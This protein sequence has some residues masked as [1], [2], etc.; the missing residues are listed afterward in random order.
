M[1]AEKDVS[2]SPKRFQ[3]WSFT[4]AVRCHAGRPATTREQALIMKRWLLSRRS[5]GF[6][7][8]LALCV[9]GITLGWRAAGLS[10]WSAFLMGLATVAGM[11]VASID[12]WLRPERFTVRRLWFPALLMVLATYLGILI[13]Q[14]LGPGPWYLALPQLLWQATPLQS[15]L[16][17]NMLL[18]LGMLMMMGA[19]AQI[20]RE[21][22]QLELARLQLRH[23]RDAAAREAAEARL[24]LLQAQIQPHFIFNTLAARQHW[25]DTADPRASALLASLTGYLRATL[26][27]FEQQTLPLEQELVAV[28]RYLD[29]M[30]AR[31]GARLRYRIDTAP[32]LADLHLPA[33][34]LLTLV[35][36][37]V[38]HGITPSLQGG[39]IALQARREGS[40]IHITVDDD[41]A[42]L[43]ANMVEGIG[44]RNTRE[45]LASLF[46]PRATLTLTARPAGGTRV[47]LTVANA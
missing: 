35:E 29:V 15:L 41:G 13:D 16:G 44:L 47:H 45:R 38:E 34:L 42:G 31:L 27:M 12:A 33:G 2:A 17:L 3:R 37:A 9:P 19:T 24:K 28:R 30:Q 4:A 8:A 7:C 26:P 23:E 1:Q 18:G 21:F 39:E 10:P 40:A 25:I 36:N 5:L 14:G 11:F 20:R 46:G 32:D 43:P 22:T 6:W